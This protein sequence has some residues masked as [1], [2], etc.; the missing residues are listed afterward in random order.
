MSKVS[1]VLEGTDMIRISLGNVGSGKTASEVREMMLNA[2]RRTTYTNVKTKIKH[3]RLLEPSMI[4]KKEQVDTIKK[5]SGEVQPVFDY[6]LNVEYWKSIK[7]PINV[8]LDEAHSIMNSRR[9]MS[10]TNVIITDWLAL[11]R[12][13]LGQSESGYGE[14]VFIT[15]LPNRIDVIAREMA[16][17]VR[18]HVCHF[19]KTCKKCG[20]TWRENSEMPESIWICPSCGDDRLRKHSHQI[21]VW[22]FS[23]MK[24][25]EMWREFGQKNFYKHYLIND[26][27][28]YFP[29]YDTLQWDNLFGEYY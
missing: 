8:V 19:Q 26:I 15:Q 17:Q 23:S 29:L 7:E 4:I 28:K 27:E 2:S 13:V 18:Y 9:A 3:G 16:H 24:E 25:F 1:Y 6:K 10:K 11:I 14:L 5:K 21:E 22:H 20:T 12:R